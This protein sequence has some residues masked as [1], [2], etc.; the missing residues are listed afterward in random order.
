MCGI[1]VISGRGLVVGGVGVG[2]GGGLRRVDRGFGGGLRVSGLKVGLSGSLPIRQLSH[3]W[4]NRWPEGEGR[5]VTYPG[6]NHLTE[7]IF[8]NR[9]MS[10][11]IT[12]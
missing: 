3:P 10:P 2:L 4:S 9:S 11:H 5:A 7:I 12:Q 8:L 6:I 1:R